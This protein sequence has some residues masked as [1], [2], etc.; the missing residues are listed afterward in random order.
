MNLEQTLHQRWSDATTLDGLLSAD[1]VTTGRSTVGSLPRATLHRKSRR[2]VN[3]TNT[4][5]QLE[6]V[7]VE[8]TPREVAI[9]SRLAEQRAR[10]ILYA[11][12]GPYQKSWKRLEPDS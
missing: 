9:V 3:R 5:E 12:G 10:G 11:P 7:V 1:R 4:G 6:E 2:T 8:I